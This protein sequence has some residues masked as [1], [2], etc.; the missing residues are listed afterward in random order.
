M[1]DFKA[2]YG[3][4]FL[5]GT[6]TS[7]DLSNKQ[8]IVDTVDE[9][10]KYTDL[11][12]AVGSVGPFPGKIFVQTADEAAAKYRELG[13]E[14]R[15]GERRRRKGEEVCPILSTFSVIA[16]MPPLLG[17]C[18]PHQLAASLQLS[19]GQRFAL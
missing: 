17:A 1:I 7:I 19:V 8:V 16:Y 4:N 2:A 9:P 12:I 15:R 10:L 13:K 14:E 18:D 6:V 3:S 5:L 11:V